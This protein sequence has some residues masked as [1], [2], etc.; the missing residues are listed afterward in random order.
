MKQHKSRQSLDN[1]KLNST[2]LITHY[3]C[4]CMYIYKKNKSRQSLDIWKLNS[5]F[6]VTHYICV[7]IYI[8][9]EYIYYKYYK[10]HKSR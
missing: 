6:L 10:Q 4:V 1:Q 7:C 2:F 3:I 9:R 5:T 8:T